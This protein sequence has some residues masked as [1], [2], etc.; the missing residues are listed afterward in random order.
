MTKF[1]GQKSNDIVV[2]LFN[3]DS[4][5]T[6]FMLDYDINITEFLDTILPKYLN[7]N[8]VSV[9]KFL[10]KVVENF[11]E[12]NQLEDENDIT[13]TKFLGDTNV[14]G[15]SW[16]SNPKK[17]TPKESPNGPPRNWRSYR[18]DERMHI[19]SDEEYMR[20]LDDR[21]LHEMHHDY[22]N[23]PYHQHYAYDNFYDNGKKGKKGKDKKKKGKGKKDKH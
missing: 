13:V 7:S 1:L 10:D 4:T 6:N 23:D 20:H 17:Y 5:V 14:A 3:L 21:W 2:T 19:D 11:L 9:T 15:F 22:A 12:E 16:S 8:D 18:E